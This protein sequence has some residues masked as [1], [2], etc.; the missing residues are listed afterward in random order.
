MEVSR[1]RESESPVL[2]FFLARFSRCFFYEMGRLDFILTHG[3]GRY[4]LV[5]VMQKG[6]FPPAH[7]YP[8]FVLGPKSLAYAFLGE[9]RMYVYGVLY[10]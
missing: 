2:I 4:S 10:D 6:R 9:G 5:Q 1:K 3:T 8:Y 7:R